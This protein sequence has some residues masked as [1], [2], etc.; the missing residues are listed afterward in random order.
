MQEA[1]IAV[2]R[3]FVE[4]TI[5]T[6][7]PDYEQY[8]NFLNDSQRTEYD[9]LTRR[10]QFLSEAA[11]TL[12]TQ[13]ETGG[14]DLGDDQI[15]SLSEQN[16][17]LRDY[18]LIQQIVEGNL[19]A[20][21][22]I[23]TAINVSYSDMRKSFDSAIQ[24]NEKEFAEFEQKFR[25]LTAPETQEQKQAPSV[26]PPPEPQKT[27]PASM[28]ES[29]KAD[30][31]ALIGQVKGYFHTQ[32]FDDFQEF[33]KEP[34]KTEYNAFTARSAFLDDSVKRMPGYLGE[35]QWLSFV[36][37][38]SDLAENNNLM[39]DFA[40]VKG[41]MQ[42][43]VLPKGDTAQAINAS[44][45]AF[46]QKHTP[47]LHAGEKEFQDY[48]G[49]VE[50]LAAESKR[51]K[52]PSPQSGND[53]VSQSMDDRRREQQ[54][55]RHEQLRRNEPK[56]REEELRVRAERM[57]ER[58][59][60]EP[61]RAR[62]ESGPPQA[63]PS[64]WRQI[65][66][67]LSQLFRPAPPAPPPP[68]FEITN[69]YSRETAPLPTDRSKDSLSEKQLNLE[70]LRQIRDKNATIPNDGDCF[71]HSVIR[72][73]GLYHKN[74]LSEDTYDEVKDLRARTVAWMDNNKDLV[75]GLCDD[76]SA[77]G[78]SV[79]FDEMRDLVRTMGA[80]NATAGDFVPFLVS[81]TL[82]KDIQINV[83]NFEETR[84]EVSR[85]STLEISSMTGEK[86]EDAP[87]EVFKYGNH[88]EISRDYYDASNRLDSR[89]KEPKQSFIEQKQ[90]SP[91]LSKASP[92]LQK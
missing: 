46:T 23:I 31:K 91:V 44:F 67:G 15:Y 68:S 62:P 36:G 65:L 30:L 87:I 32:S 72:S 78:E 34:F 58:Q 1:V 47:A 69:P 82:G 27:A 29:V 73:G 59:Q 77:G 5:R 40:F 20:D 26:N 51:Q 56:R 79:T 52:A 84:P 4:N 89:Y 25:T 16:E 9:R 50:D 12:L 14:P 35:E 48:K 53:S 63:R 21:E 18:A 83:Y 85:D 17:V 41:M 64:L 70:T 39:R 8:A 86:S 37:H 66:D 57:R 11:D 33:L 54:R 24:E 81:S 43:G 28:D 61:P 38:V 92:P 45:L 22:N 19:L 55:R 42:E 10:A 60:A 2:L 75:N 80:W 7:G 13:E 88:Y 6:I 49:L 90:N 74:A 76:F 71:F 3:D